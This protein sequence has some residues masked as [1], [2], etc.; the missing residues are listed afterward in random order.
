MQ[1]QFNKTS[2][3]CLETVLQQMQHTEVTQELRLPDGMPDIGRVLSTWGQV[4]LRSKQW[5]GDGIQI[6]G[7]VMVW[8]LYAPEDGTEPRSIDSWI[9]FQMNWGIS[10]PMREGPMRIMPLLTVADGRSV[11][12]RKLMF[13]C[14]VSA[15]LQALS[16]QDVPIY[17][18][19]EIPEDVQLRRCIYPVTVPVEGGEKTFQIDEELTLPDVGTVPT[20]LLSLTVSPEITEKRVMSDK[21][22]FK[23]Q[24]WIHSVCRYEDGQIRSSDQSVQFSQLSDLDKSYGTDAQ[25]DIRMAVTGLEED[26]PQPG[27]IR[28]KC[29]LVG[30]YLVDDR[31]SLELIQDAYSPQREVQ[32]E[33]SVLD[34][35][36]ILDQRTDYLQAEQS[37][38]GQSGQ[39]AD[40]RFLAGQPTVRHSGKSA[41]L[42]LSGRFQILAYD[43]EETI[44]GAAS[45]WEGNLELCADDAAEIL[46]DIRPVGKVQ[47]MGTADEINMNSQIQL[48]IQIGKME[49]LPAVTGLELGPI[50]EGD[51]SRPSV[52]LRKGNCDLLWDIAKQSNSTVNAIRR[53]NG[54]D[55]DTAP[56]G[57]LLIPVI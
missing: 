4:I 35:P 29:S 53:A 2:I 13:R 6:N 55:G 18:P 57:M 23:G 9:P 31:Y 41:D 49:H 50:R 32:M 33:E 10:N 38:S 8:T 40:A 1:L 45:R 7:G 43:D 48:S 39:V 51:P 20:K 37:L 24:L 15:M 47:T 26:M 56:E 34:F 30:Q 22:I 5:Q 28:V 17:T 42:E 11:S 46:A 14:N 19:G 16:A 44:Q 54:I 52:I 12:S 25:V 3:R 27:L 36:V 21:V